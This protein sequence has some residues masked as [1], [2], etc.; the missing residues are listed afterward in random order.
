M[1]DQIIDMKKER[2]THGDI[3]LKPKNL[4]SKIML[5][6]LAGYGADAPGLIGIL[7]EDLDLYQI[8]AIAHNWNIVIN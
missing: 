3:R 2:T 7:L 4:A 1:T 5:N 8:L 6:H